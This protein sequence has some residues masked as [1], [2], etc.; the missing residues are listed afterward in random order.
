MG[1]PRCPGAPAPSSVVDGETIV[2]N[3]PVRVSVDHGTP[4]TGSLLA[5][6]TQVA[7]RNSQRWGLPLVKAVD[8]LAR[9]LIPAQHAVDAP[10]PTVAAGF[11]AQQLL[12]AV[13]SCRFSLRIDVYTPI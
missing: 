8:S 9:R 3:V 5:D 7:R 11:F 13:E 4:R 10:G 1:T 2:T 6:T 12:K